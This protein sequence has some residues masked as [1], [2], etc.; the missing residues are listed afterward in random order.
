MNILSPLISIGLEKVDD[1]LKMARL[2]LS[3]GQVSILELSSFEASQA[4]RN[5][6][7]ANNLILATGIE[8]KEVLIR[9][10]RLPLT[11]QKDIDQALGFQA[12]ALLPYPLE[13]AFLCYQ[14]VSKG[15]ESTDLTLFSVHR[16]SLESHLKKWHGNGIESESVGSIPSALCDFA[17]QFLLFQKAF[18]V[19]HIQNRQMSCSLVNEGKD[20]ASF[21]ES[22]GLNLLKEESG[23]NGHSFESIDPLSNAFKRLQKGVIR[24]GFALKKECR[25]ISIEAVAVTGDAARSP[26]FCEALVQPLSYPLIWSSPCGSYSAEDLHAFAAPI[27]LAIGALEKKYPINFRQKEFVFPNRWKRLQFPLAFYCLSVLLVCFAFLFFSTSYLQNEKDQI[28]Q[29][30]VDLLGKLS[31]SHEAFEAAF[32]QKFP[33]AH[34]AFDGEPP[35]VKNLSLEEIDARLNFLQ[36]EIQATPDAF[37]LQ[38]NTPR[39]SDFLAWLTHHPV[40]ASTDSEGKREAKIG[41]ENLTYS[42][43]KRPQQGKKQEKYQVKIE[44]EFTSKTPKIAR[45]FHDALI[46]P[47]DWIDPKGEVKW[48]S[49]KGKYKTSFFLKDKTAYPSG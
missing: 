38:P 39:V 40:V 44:L 9:S 31:R 2:S 41:I 47:N 29:S 49:S 11:K 43:M 22:D 15:E 32:V 14:I 1:D 30:Y 27:G 36:K 6:K 8:A 18:L 7:S 21:T 45:E 28:K 20:L 4:S 46:A 33:D 37:P 25:G 34:A 26:S 35:A 42:M 12:E 24:M 10:L 48:N 23:Q 17:D 13:E 5:L 3:K 19:L 16:D